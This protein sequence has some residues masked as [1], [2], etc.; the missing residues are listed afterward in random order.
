MAT[1]QMCFAE[2]TGCNCFGQWM[3]TLRATYGSSIYSPSLP[4]YFPFHP[5]HLFPSLTNAH[6]PDQTPNNCDVNDA[7]GPDV[8]RRRNGWGHGDVRRSSSTFP[9]PGNPNAN[10]TTPATTTPTV[11]S[12]TTTT[13]PPAA[14]PFG[15]FGGA[16]AGAASGNPFGVDLGLM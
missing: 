2:S 10:S 1:S 8:S 7:H 4:F 14:N 16:G 12:P 11:T 15:M 13:T 3:G 9:A 6:S 5:V